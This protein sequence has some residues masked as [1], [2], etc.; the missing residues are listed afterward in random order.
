MTHTVLSLIV[1]HRNVLYDKSPD[2][3]LCR[4]NFEPL[5]D[6]SQ[7]LPPP[8]PGATWENLE[9]ILSSEIKIRHRQIPGD[10]TSM[11]NVK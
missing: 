11:R 2:L 4:R 6:N 1:M 7:V 10:S 9:E 8:A 5:T 3:T